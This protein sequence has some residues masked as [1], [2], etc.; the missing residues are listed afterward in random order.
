MKFEKY[1][2]Y[3]LIFITWVPSS[4]AGAVSDL[5]PAFAISPQSQ[6][7]FELPGLEQP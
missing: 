2:K 7:D 1:I 6:T 5:L 3:I 4:Q